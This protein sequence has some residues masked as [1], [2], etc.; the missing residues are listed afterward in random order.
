MGKHMREALKRVEYVSRIPK[1]KPVRKEVGSWPS[2]PL[3]S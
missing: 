3:R 1:T 2:T